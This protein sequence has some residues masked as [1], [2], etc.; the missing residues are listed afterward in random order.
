MGLAGWLLLQS[1]AQDQPKTRGGGEGGGS[2]D[3]DPDNVATLSTS[4]PLGV[5]GSA[6]VDEQQGGSLP[7]FKS[8]SGLEY[9]L[10]A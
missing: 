2:E 10:H 6:G 1:P 3:G 8:N 7:R 9:G 5:A 4:R